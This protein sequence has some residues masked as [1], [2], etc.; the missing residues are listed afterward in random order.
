[1]KP[2]VLLLSHTY[3]K[4]AESTKHAK[5]LAETYLSLKMMEWSNVRP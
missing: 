4:D 3:A 2:R 1:M 5:P